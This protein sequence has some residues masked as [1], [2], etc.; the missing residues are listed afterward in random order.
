VVGLVSVVALLSVFPAAR[1]ASP[2]PR[3]A[4]N[5]L[6]FGAAAVALAV[7]PIERSVTPPLA[8]VFALALGAS[9]GLAQL[10][11][12][13]RGDTESENIGL[14]GLVLFAVGFGS[15]LALPTV[16]VMFV[17]G[18]VL[19]LGATGAELHRR[20][21]DTEGPAEL[22]LWVLLG[23]RLAPSASTIVCGLALGTVWL[24]LHVV[25]LRFARLAPGPPSGGLALPLVASFVHVDER[26]APALSIVVAAVALVETAGALQS[27]VARGRAHLET[28][29]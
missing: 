3:T 18:A 15:A 9:V 23:T 2:W 21:G 12:G 26:L 25:A 17:V 13:A 19:T 28:R 22:V 11:Q 6:A 10:L 16:I 29:R 27:V 24:L 4:A 5:V 7:L 20:L 1:D 14:V 8:L